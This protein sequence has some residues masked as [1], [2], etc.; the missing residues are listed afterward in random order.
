MV[1]L[2]KASKGFTLIEVLVSTL[3]VGFIFSVIFLYI[4]VQIYNTQEALSKRKRRKLRKREKKG[5]EEEG[6]RSRN[7][8]QSSESFEF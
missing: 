7:M 3:I 6:E 4:L 2:N 5:K 1:K 8:T